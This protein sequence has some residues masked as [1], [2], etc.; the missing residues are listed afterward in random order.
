MFDASAQR[1]Q[2]RGA[3]V[4]V[5]TIYELFFFFD[6]AEESDFSSLSEDS[7]MLNT[8]HVGGI[9]YSYHAARMCLSRALHKLGSG[10]IC[11]SRECSRLQRRHVDIFGEEKHEYEIAKSLPER[12]QEKK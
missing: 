1:E 8:L 2:D 4:C 11:Q 5:K 9:M 6:T 10:D 3:S 7:Q 12:G